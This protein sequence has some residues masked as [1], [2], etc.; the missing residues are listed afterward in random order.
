MKGLAIGVS[1][2]RSQLCNLRERDLGVLKMQESNCE[3]LG[4][5]L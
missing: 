5:R 1:E 3:G 2:G 4:G